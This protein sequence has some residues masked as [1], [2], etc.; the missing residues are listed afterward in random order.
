[1]KSKILFISL[2]SFLAFGCTTTAKIEHNKDA[3]VYEKVRSSD[4]VKII[5]PQAGTNKIDLDFRYEK[6]C[7]IKF[8]QGGA[9][10]PPAAAKDSDEF[11]QNMKDEAWK[12]GANAVYMDSYMRFGGD[13]TLRAVGIRILTGKS[14]LGDDKL[15]EKLA[16]AVNAKNYSVVKKL[17]SKTDKNRL[18]RSPGDSMVLDRML[19]YAATRGKECS[20]KITNLLISYGAQIDGL[21]EKSGLKSTRDEVIH[22]DTGKVVLSSWDNI[23]ERPDFSIDVLNSVNGFMN[24]SVKYGIGDSNEALK[25][26]IAY[27]KI[28]GKLQTDVK[29]ACKADD[30]SKMC[31]LKDNLRRSSTGSDALLKVIA[32]SKMK[33]SE[34]K[35]FKSEVQKLKKRTLVI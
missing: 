33:T 34:K 25:K 9:W 16:L 2:V 12:C 29:S 21:Q 19:F 23:K 18:N 6:V 35:K 10:A 13:V 32:T 8:E 1:M 30:T 7:E 27:R 31:I 22:C 14:Q 20:T 15:L 17:V 3:K 11:D 24:S 4:D 26:L 28:V 5:R